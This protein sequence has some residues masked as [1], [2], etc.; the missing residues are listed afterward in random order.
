MYFN[1][2]MRACH[3]VICC[4]RRRNFGRAGN[5]WP[6]KTNW[7][8]HCGSGSSDLYYV[9]LQCMASHLLSQQPAFLTNRVTRFWFIEYEIVLMNYIF[10]HQLIQFIK[11]W[12][13]RFSVISSYI[14]HQNLMKF[15]FRNQHEILLDLDSGH[16]WKLGFNLY[17]FP[18]SGLRM[19]DWTRSS[20]RT[21]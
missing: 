10:T 16:Q 14:Y 8:M 2:S 1:P 17:Y 3:P 5:Q 19:R 20:L 6:P 18:Q 7:K 9:A 11:I 4:C 15:G 21:T 13:Y 12:I